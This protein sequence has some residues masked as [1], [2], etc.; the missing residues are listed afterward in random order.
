MKLVTFGCSFT[1]DNY[2][3]TWADILA[4][5]L[6]LPLDN[7]AERG[8]GSE[9][10]VNRIL[11]SDLDN[12]V[13]AV[14]WPSADRLDL[15]TDATV[16]HLQNDLEYAAWLDGHRPEFV[17]LHGQ[18]SQTQGFNL[19]GNWPR[20][21]KEHYYKY[22]Y[23]SF[24][25]VHSLYRNIIT[26]QLYL[27]SIGVPYIMSSSMPLRYP[28]I[29]WKTAFEIEPTIWSRIDFDKFVPASDSQGFVNWC[30]HNHKPFA[31]RYYPAESA[32]QDYCNTFIIPK[33]HNEFRNIT[34]RID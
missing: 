14:M 9:F 23:S 32:H 6:N 7:R 27:S 18:R 22:L 25:S 26:A 2:Q 24:Q 28:L 10:V 13:V 1:R 20:G 29:L 16:P 31:N 15:W 4:A 12:A 19:N 8:A 30:L 3:S 5:E 17:D 33:A 34:R 11:A 21:Y